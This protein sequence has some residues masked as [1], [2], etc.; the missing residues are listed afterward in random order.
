MMTHIIR[1]IKAYF[2]NRVAK[3]Y[4]KFS[5]DTNVTGF[6]EMY[7]AK[8]KFFQIV[9]LILIIFGISFTLYQCWFTI[10]EYLDSPT[11]TVIQQ[12]R[13]IPKYPPLHLC[14]SHWMFWVDWN[15][16]TSQDLN[17][18]RESFLHAMS[19]SKTIFVDKPLENFTKA[20]ENFESMMISK[21]YHNLSS[22][23][24][25]IARDYPIGITFE[26]EY[27]STNFSVKFHDYYGSNLCYVMSIDL[28]R[29][30]KKKRGDKSI[31]LQFDLDY[32]IQ[33]GF[34]TE[35]EMNYYQRAAFAAQSD[36]KQK[37]QLFGNESA[38]FVAPMI[39]TDGTGNFVLPDPNY[40]QYVL[41]LKGT[42]YRWI[43]SDDQPCTNEYGTDFSG[44]HV[45]I[46]QR[47]CDIMN[48]W[49]NIPCAK[50]EELS[51]RAYNVDI[52]RKSIVYVSSKLNESQT[53]SLYKPSSMQSVLKQ[54]KIDDFDLSQCFA[55][56]ITP[57]EQWVYETSVVT[58][59]RPYQF[60]AN[61][62]S[63]TEVKIQYPDPDTIIVMT[64]TP[65]TTWQKMLSDIGGMLGL[66][67]G[68]TLL[69]FV[70]IIYLCCCSDM[71]EIFSH[72]FRMDYLNGR[73]ESCACDLERAST[74]MA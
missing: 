2:V 19:L 9:W 42:V 68:A 55:K 38:I 54:I 18:D 34:I 11:N 37:L 25:S 3:N 31:T 73:K 10:N 49:N 41:R 24:L 59:L 70:Q 53:I 44:K 50:F 46:C 66:W 67:L 48:K 29:V 17:L 14:Y 74:N 28:D 40:F 51:T 47:T 63:S 7:Y 13:E 56:C 6:K 58:N 23:Y 35:L 22:F 12:L 64:E 21:Q 65:S 45:K 52:C 27:N 15:K 30:D 36:S 71:D 61:L 20:K 60:R 39:D 62:P 57:C 43:S 8:S 1:F 26:Q 32:N 4:A 72:E 69:S 5:D 33:A 16:V